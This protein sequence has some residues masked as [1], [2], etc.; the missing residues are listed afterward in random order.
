[1]FYYARIMLCN[2]HYY[3]WQGGKKKAQKGEMK[4]GGGNWM[5]GVYV[6]F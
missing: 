6:K 3:K 4:R 1:M 5:I 2:L